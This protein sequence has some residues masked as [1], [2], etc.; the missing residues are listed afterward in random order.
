MTISDAPP[1]LTPKQAAFVREYLIDLNATQA[2]TRAGY[3][4]KT[5]NE[6]GA[7]LLSKAHVREAIDAGKSK[8]SEKLDV[9]AEFVLQ[10]LVAEVNADLAD[11]YT[12]AGDLKP[13][14]AWPEIWRQGLVAGVEV[15][16]LFDGYGED[17]RQVGHVKKIKLSDRLRR[18]ELIG[19]HIRVNAFQEQIAVSGVEALGE[20]IAR[21]KAIANAAERLAAPALP[22]PLALPPASVPST[23]EVL[24]A[25]PSAP[26]APPPPSA[27]SPAPS[28]PADWNAPARYSPILP[29][30]W[31]ERPAF[32]D[33]DY[34][35]LESGLIGSRNR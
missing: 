17:R 35:S 18:L 22:A 4:A 34:Q 20:R 7:Q 19:K 29:A 1:V 26:A 8:R 2:A 23:P 6:Q 5:A 27:P 11:L 16:A 10:R 21:A 3:S 31:P 14:E 12:D 9:D 24:L 30:A 13:I 28:A 33:C 15:E 32:A 25:E